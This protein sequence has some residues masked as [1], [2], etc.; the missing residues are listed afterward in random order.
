MARTTASRVDAFYQG[1]SCAG[2]GLVL[3]SH[4]GARWREMALVD[5]GMA[6]YLRRV[7]GAELSLQTTHS[8]SPIGDCSWR[9][10]METL[11][12]ELRAMVVAQMLLVED[13]LIL[14]RV[15]RAWRDSVNW[16]FNRNWVQQLQAGEQFASS[17]SAGRYVLKHHADGRVS[18]VH[19][20]S[21]FLYLA[22]FPCLDIG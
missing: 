6:R 18:S 2:L 20:S 14:C 3:M 19:T 8:S 16:S 7:S 11:P 22:L 17:M 12:E 15:S 1:E 9:G 4:D 5:Q 21:P 10:V 13:R